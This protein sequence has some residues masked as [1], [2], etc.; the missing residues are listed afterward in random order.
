MQFYRYDI[1]RRWFAGGGTTGNTTLGRIGMVTSMLIGNHK[2]LTQHLTSM[3]SKQQ[4]VFHKRLIKTV[5]WLVEQP[6]LM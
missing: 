4:L 2:L 6:Q 5:L 1:I 3:A